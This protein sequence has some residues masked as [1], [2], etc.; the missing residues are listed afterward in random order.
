[1]RRGRRAGSSGRS[2][3]LS[4]T[5]VE[6]PADEA[7]GA[8]TSPLSAIGIAVVALLIVGGAAVAWLVP[9]AAIVLVWPILFFVPGWVLVRRVVPNMRISAAVVAA[10]VTITYA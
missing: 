5:A 1:T 2:W 3:S 8:G 6:P 7:A 9:L 4:S 10:I